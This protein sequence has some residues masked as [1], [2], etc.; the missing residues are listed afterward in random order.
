MDN[1]SNSS[2]SCA[3]SPDDVDDENLSDTGPAQLW[4]PHVSLKPLKGDGDISDDK[5]VIEDNLL[6]GATFKVNDNLI[7][8]LVKMKDAF[9][10]DWLP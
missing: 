3:K 9:D 2:P 5:V 1:P 7:E 4:N 6:Y 10:L 8:M